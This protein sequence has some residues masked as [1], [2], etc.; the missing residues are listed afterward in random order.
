M[1]SASKRA[2]ESTAPVSG[3]ETD[4][5]P[6]IEPPVRVALD[7][8]VDCLDGIAADA[9]LRRWC[10]QP[11]FRQRLLARL[12]R[13]HQLTSIAEQPLMDAA[14][15]ALC[16]LDSD[17]FT[18]CAR[19]AGVIIHANAFVREIHAPRVAALKQCFGAELY[20]LALTH[21]DHAST[22]ACA[23]DDLD[24][25]EAAVEHDG[26]RCLERWWQAQTVALRAWLRLG[27][28]GQ[29]EEP[30]TIAADTA[31]VDIARL[32]ATHGL[33]QA[34]DKERAGI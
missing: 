28:A 10:T 4:I 9:M 17:D 6:A 1:N 31:A 16:Q 33:F 22:E 32:A 26:R 14:D 12:Q 24:A 3:I 21:R 29:F 19:A 20:S 23:E 13:R 5:E 27:W 15:Q 8:W 30:E 34:D 7:H 2:S 18:A 11:R 25:L